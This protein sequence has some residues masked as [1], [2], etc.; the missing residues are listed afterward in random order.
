[1]V[2]NYSSEN[3]YCADDIR[4]A[5]NFNIQVGNKMRYECHVDSNPISCVLNC[6]SHPIGDG[7]ELIISNDINSVGIDEIER[8]CKIVTPEAGNLLIF[9]GRNHPH[10]VRPLNKP[11]GLRIILGM[12]YYT[13]ECPES[14]RPSDLDYHLGYK[15]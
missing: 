4:H 15:K 1:M 8:D 7:G 2:S 3:I 12:N 6:T 5:L 11:E 13:N 10:Y 9:D 14:L